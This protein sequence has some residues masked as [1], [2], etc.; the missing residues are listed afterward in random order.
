MPTYPRTKK[1]SKGFKN[2][3]LATLWKSMSAKENENL[4]CKN[5]RRLRNIPRNDYIR[6][7]ILFDKHLRPEERSYRY[8]QAVDIEEMTTDNPTDFWC[9]IKKLTC[10]PRKDKSIP[11][12][13]VNNEGEFIRDQNKAFEKWKTGFQNL[14]NGQDSCDFDENH[15]SR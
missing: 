6:T 15:F 11:I 5:D 8:A 1:R 14:Y 10:N 2:K 13:I 9:K 4:K 3:N 12:E 7:H